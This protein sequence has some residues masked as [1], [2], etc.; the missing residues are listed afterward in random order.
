MIH[1]NYNSDSFKIFLINEQEVLDRN[2]Q[3]KLV[4]LKKTSEFK[5]IKAKFPQNLSKKIGQSQ[6]F[7]LKFIFFFFPKKVEID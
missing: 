2:I 4:N 1:I 7:L 6:R 3:E 5:K